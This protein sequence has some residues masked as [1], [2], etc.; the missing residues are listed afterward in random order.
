MHRLLIAAL[1][2]AF[3]LPCCSK[4]PTLTGR[5]KNGYDETLLF[6][7]DSTV[8]LGKEGFAGG[9]QGRYTAAGDTIRVTTQIA[10]DDLGRFYNVFVFS[11]IG[12]KL[13]MESTTLYR[14]TDFSTISTRELAKRLRKSEERLAFTRVEEKAP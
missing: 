9:E 4:Q 3:I 8:V 1:L 7:A 2:L 12:E 13:F 10:A 5:W 11:R 14:G 6:N